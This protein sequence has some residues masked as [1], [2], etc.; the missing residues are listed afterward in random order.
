MVNNELIDSSGNPIPCTYKYQWSPTYTTGSKT[1]C[2]MLE[3][4]GYTQLPGSC[5]SANGSYSAK[6]IVSKMDGNPLFF[7]VDGDTFTPTTEFQASQIV[8]YYDSSGSWPFD[9]DS[10][11]NKRFHNFS[12]TSEIRY[13]FRYDN[14]R[15]YI[16]D[17]V[18]DD[19]MWV[20]INGKL[21]A[22]LG[23]IHIAVDGSIEIGTDGNATSTVTA[24]FS[25]STSSPP[26]SRKMSA[27]LGLQ[28][29]K[30]YEIAVFHAERQSNGS[31][32]KV[33]FPAFNLSPSKCERCVTGGCVTTTP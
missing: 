6:Y 33:T 29:G 11:G 24:T 32:L 19:D 25:S 2:Q 20:F 4:T 30:L 17:F 18:G 13:W 15:P 9:V 23:G 26:S 27:A 5:V 22:D 10:S 12:F 7:P 3:E 1:D 31:S 21:A 28:P 16:L 14:S 8:P